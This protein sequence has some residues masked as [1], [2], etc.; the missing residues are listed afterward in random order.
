MKEM[1]FTKAIS[2]AFDEEMERDP[3]VFIIGEDIG[4]H[5]GELMGFGGLFKKYGP[6]RIR[7]TPISETAILGGAIGA[8]ATGMR[9]IASLMFVDFMGVCGDELLNQLQMRYMLGGKV[10][11]PP[12]VAIQRS[13]GGSS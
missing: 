7:E 12:R 1:T 8:A 11:L 6:K 3:A 5:F 10:K 4:E 2:E 13:S 9:P